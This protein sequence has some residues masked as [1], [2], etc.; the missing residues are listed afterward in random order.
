MYREVPELQASGSEENAALSTMRC[1][2]EK[3]AH[4]TE[5][6]SYRSGALALCGFGMV[7]LLV[8]YI[9]EHRKIGN[10]D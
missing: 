10:N 3:K 1:C 5:M 6:D 9:V 8:F 2:T 7:F 4:S